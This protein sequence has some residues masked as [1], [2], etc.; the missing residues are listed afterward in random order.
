MADAKKFFS[1]KNTYE[2]VKALCQD[3][4]IFSSNLFSI[5]LKFGEFHCLIEF[6]D[7]V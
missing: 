3:K 2:Q 4:G 5:Y 7:L 6:L 1:L